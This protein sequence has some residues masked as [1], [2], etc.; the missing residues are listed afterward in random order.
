MAVNKIQLAV[1]Y[2]KN[3]DPKSA[4]YTHYYAEVDTRKTLTTDGLVEHIM[5]HNVA[6]GPEAVAALL[7]AQRHQ[8]LAPPHHPE[9]KK[10]K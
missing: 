2:R 7:L 3:N 4:M 6:V 5:G 1:N 9:A 8:Q 10:V